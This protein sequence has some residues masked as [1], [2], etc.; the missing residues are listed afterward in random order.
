MSKQMA[1][2]LQCFKIAVNSHD[3]E[4]PSHPP[5][6]GIA[7]NPFDIE[8]LGLEEGEE[9]L[10]G[11]K[12]YSDSGI[13]GNFRVLCDYEDNSQKVETTEAIGVYA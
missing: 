7:C 10:P 8:R 2:N 6:Y 3:R 5:A 1:K 13:T 12:V 11:I 4:N 9:I